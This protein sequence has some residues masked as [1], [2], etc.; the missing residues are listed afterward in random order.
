[1][2]WKMKTLEFSKWILNLGD[3]KL[4]EDDDGDA[5]VEMLQDILIE[6]SVDPI[7]DIV[8]ATYPDFLGNLFNAKFFEDRAI[9]APTLEV[10]EKMNAFAMSLIPGEEKKYLSCDSVCK[11]DVE[12][13]VDYNWLTTEFLNHRLILKK[14]VPVILSSS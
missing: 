2:M 6:R 12:G 3:G 13:G 11:G 7:K 5:T 4:G 9:L 14:R 8:E 10:V 1:M